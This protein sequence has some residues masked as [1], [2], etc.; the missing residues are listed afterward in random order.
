MKNDISAGAILLL[1]AVY[2]FDG[3]SGITALFSA[4]FVHEMGHVIAIKALGGNIK[5]ASFNLSGLCMAYSGVNSAIGE[6]M[7]IAAGPLFGFALALTASKYGG[8]T[9]NTYLLKTAGISLL[10]SLYNCLPA[11]PL[12]GGRLL[13]FLFDKCFDSYVSDKVMDASGLAVGGALLF[14]GAVLI[15]K[16]YGAALFIAGVWILIKQTGIVKT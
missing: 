1:S 9:Q 5:S 3:L 16:S 8:I 2:F 15:R 10:L 7:C 13:K 4:V 12:D 14:I 6:V 11:L